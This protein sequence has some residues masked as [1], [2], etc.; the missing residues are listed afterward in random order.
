MD[1]SKKPLIY[2]PL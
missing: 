1:H 2:N